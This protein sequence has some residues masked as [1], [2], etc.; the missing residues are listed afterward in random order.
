M[1][2]GSPFYFGGCA[3]HLPSEST[4]MKKKPSSDFDAVSGVA[5]SEPETRSSARVKGLFPYAVRFGATKTLYRTP[6]IVMDTCTLE[7]LGCCFHPPIMHSLFQC[8][9]RPMMPLSVS[10]HV[11][12]F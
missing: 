1:H 10:G 5:E 9:R 3:R 8:A 4:K 7:I 2:K 11:C 12:V 6:G